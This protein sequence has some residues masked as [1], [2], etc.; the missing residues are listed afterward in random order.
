[1]HRRGDPA[2]RRGDPR[3]RAPAGEGAVQPAGDARGGRPV[4]R[5]HAAPA[6]PG[7]PAM[8]VAVLGAGGRVGT[9]VCRAVEDAEDL[10]LVARIGSTD[11]IERLADTGAEAVVD[12]TRP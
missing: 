9:E 10:E 5:A 2:Q 4:R 6:G 1:G 12:F 11:P 7:G 3:R 8:K